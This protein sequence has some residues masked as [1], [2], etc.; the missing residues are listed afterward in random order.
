[1]CLDAAEGI[2]LKCGREYGFYKG[3]ARANHLD[4]LAP[5]LYRFLTNS[6]DRYRKRFVKI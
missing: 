3:N 4:K 5:K 1:M 2:K 6:L